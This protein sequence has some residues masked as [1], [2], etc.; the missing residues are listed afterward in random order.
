MLFKKSLNNLI[1]GIV[2]LRLIVLV[3]CSPLHFLAVL[4]S[5]KPSD[6]APRANH[7]I[8]VY[9][10]A[11]LESSTDYTVGNELAEIRLGVQAGFQSAKKIYPTCTIELDNSSQIQLETQGAFQQRTVNFVRN[12]KNSDYQQNIMVVGFSRSS[13]A[14]SIAKLFKTSKVRG[15]SVGSAAN[16]QELNSD[17]YSVAYSLDSQWKRLALLFKEQRCDHVFAYFPL[18]NGYSST[19]KEMFKA[20]KSGEIKNS[21]AELLTLQFSSKDCVFLGGN[22]SD[23]VM[24]LSELIQKTNVQKIIGPSDF[25]FSGA[26]VKTLINK[27]NRPL[28]ILAPSGWPQLGFERNQRTRNLRSLARLK[29]LPE[30]SPILAYSYDAGVLSTAHLCTSIPFNELVKN[31]DLKTLLLRGYDAVSAGGNLVGDFYIHEFISDPKK[32]SGAR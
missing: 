3:G 8:Y 23:L 31:K 13:N 14:K 29:K 16:L 19:L 18:T 24:T 27:T 5:A 1:Y 12:L 22:Y 17:F 28:T 6:S 26:E 4:S 32:N 20:S 21:A 11:T 30:P 9:D 10:T 15:L 2:T 7:K 25:A